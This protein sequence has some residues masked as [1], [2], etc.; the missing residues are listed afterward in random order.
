MT[1]IQGIVIHAGIEILPLKGF[2]KIN[3]EFNTRVAE[4]EA[5]LNSVYADVVLDSIFAD[6]TMVGELA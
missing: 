6:D 1:A 4:G 2:N 3:D 5:I